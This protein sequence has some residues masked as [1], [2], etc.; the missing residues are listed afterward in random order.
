VQPVLSANA[1]TGVVTWRG[2]RAFSVKRKT[3]VR[4]EIGEEAGR[5]RPLGGLQKRCGGGVEVRVGR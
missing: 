1:C 4:A 3:G 2:E 5:T